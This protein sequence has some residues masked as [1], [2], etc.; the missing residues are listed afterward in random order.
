MINSMLSKASS[1]VGL[2][3]FKANGGLI[4]MEAT[5]VVNGE[6]SCSETGGGRK[7][8]GNHGTSRERERPG[9]CRVNYT[10]LERGRSFPWGDL[11]PN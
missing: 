2:T 7:V 6:S 9:V 4:W 1:R 3:E 8:E 5:V 10:S 11:S